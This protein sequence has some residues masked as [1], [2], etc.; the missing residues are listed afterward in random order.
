MAF[1][2]IVTPAAQPPH[3]GALRP[4]LLRQTQEFGVAHR[5]RRKIEAVGL[6]DMPTFLVPAA[7]AF[8]VRAVPHGDQAQLDQA[9]VRFLDLRRRTAEGEAEGRTIGR[10]PW[11]QS[12][13]WVKRNSQSTACTIRG[14]MPSHGATAFRAASNCPGDLSTYPQEWA[15][16]RGDSPAAFPSTE[17]E[18]RTCVVGDHQS[19]RR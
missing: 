2:A 18:F 9:V 13:G 3:G 19:R 10:L 5:D 1:L 14:E 8:A 15:S 11:S 16:R 7:I 4:P 17:A 6:D 12:C